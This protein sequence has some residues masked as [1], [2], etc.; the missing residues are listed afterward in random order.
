MLDFIFAMNAYGKHAI[1]MRTAAHTDRETN[2]LS[3]PT[4]AKNPI[5]GKHGIASQ[6]RHNT[7]L[8]SVRNKLERELSI[9][10]YLCHTAHNRVNHL[11]PER[12]QHNRLVSDQ[13]CRNPAVLVKVP[14]ANLRASA[15][16]V[17]HS[18][19]T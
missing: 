6:R 2:M 13:I 8:F 15:A 14:L 7:S 1:A 19:I 10:T 16:S 11:A 9:R 17:V 18:C 5:C 3:G 4:L 12:P